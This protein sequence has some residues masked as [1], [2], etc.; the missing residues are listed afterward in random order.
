MIKASDLKYNI[1]A[2]REFKD[3]TGRSPFQLTNE[4]I[5]D[6]EFFGVLV[7]V[8]LKHKKYAEAAEVPSLEDVEKDVSLRDQKPVWEAFAYWLNLKEEDESEKK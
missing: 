4:E 8:G 1:A 3:L 6:P 2:L 5:L 7:Y